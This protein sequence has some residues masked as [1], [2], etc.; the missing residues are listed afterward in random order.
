MGRKKNN[1]FKAGKQNP[2]IKEL[3]KK[4]DEKKNKDFARKYK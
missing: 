1:K 3:F 2:K 4:I